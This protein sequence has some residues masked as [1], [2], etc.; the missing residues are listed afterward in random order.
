[1]KIYKRGNIVQFEYPTRY[2]VCS[3]FVR[4]GEFYE[5]PMPDIRGKYFSMDKFMDL[6]T[7]KNEGPRRFEK[8]TYF[9]DWGGYNI[10]GEIITKFFLTFGHDLRDKEK[11]VLDAIQEFMDRGEKF[12]VI[13]THTNKDLAYSKALIA[14]EMAH[15]FYYLIP[16]YKE[17]CSEI[18]KTLSEDAKSKINAKLKFYGYSDF[19]YEDESQAY[20]SSDSYKKSYSRFWVIDK[21]KNEILEQD[22]AAI[23]AYQKLLKKYYN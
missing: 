15:G 17:A 14:H 10:P 18:Y 13:A 5:S 19:T 3:A 4:M 9:D 7:A 20:L 21:K 6:Y 23:K 12:Y 8:F 2:H 11:V 16:E 22:I 1:M